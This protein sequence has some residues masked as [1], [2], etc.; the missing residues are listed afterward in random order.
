[1]RAFWNKQ[2]KVSVPSSGEYKMS[3]DRPPVWDNVCAVIGD[4]P[5]LLRVIFTHGDVIYNPNHLPLSADLI[6]H[7]KVH[8]KQQNYN[9]TDAAL[10]WG[11]YL[12]DP[13]FR[14]EQEAEAYGK[15]YDVVCGI[16]KDRNGRAKFL[17]QLS[18]SFSG[19]LYNK[20]IGQV[21]AMQLIRKYSNNK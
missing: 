7:E 1:M 2:K 4:G 20:C 11:K 17:T 15:Q 5:H 19:P 18:M 14:I 21:E 13:A 16:L 6:A 12:R 8:M 9:D 10:W 3:Y